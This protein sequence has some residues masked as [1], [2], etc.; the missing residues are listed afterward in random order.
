[1]ADQDDVTINQELF[2]RGYLAWFDPALRI[3]GPAGP[4]GLLDFLVTMYA[5]GRVRARRRLRPVLQTGRLVAS[6]LTSIVRAVNRPNT[7]RDDRSEETA[8]GWQMMALAMAGRGAVMVGAMAAGVGVW[9]RGD[10]QLR[11]RRPQ[12]ILWVGFSEQGPKILLIQCDY[13]QRRLTAVPVTPE[14][15]LRI[16]GRRKEVSLG[17]LQPIYRSLDQNTLRVAL[18]ETIG[19]AGL[20]YVM[21]NESDLDLILRPTGSHIQI[22]PDAGRHFVDAMQVGRLVSSLHCKDIDLLQRTLG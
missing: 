8:A 12:M 10:L 14:L 9:T 11:Q 17:D 4:A 7:S 5:T 2:R 13:F 22:P 15:R 3:T 18:E 20:D 21:G 16:D 6:P 19:L 1:M